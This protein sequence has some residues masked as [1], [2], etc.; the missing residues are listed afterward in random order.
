MA[1]KNGAHV[2]GHGW[3]A[4][5][6]DLKGDALLITK[7]VLTVERRH[8]PTYKHAERVRK[9][10]AHRC[11]DLA[12]GA[13]RQRANG[14][15]LDRKRERPFLPEHRK[16]ASVHYWDT[17]RRCGRC[18]RGC[19]RREWSLR[20]TRVQDLPGSLYRSSPS[21]EPRAAVWPQPSQNACR[22]IASTLD[23]APQTKLSNHS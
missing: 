11:G 3:F 15:V 19:R 21:P 18:D 13:D 8:F 6:A 10:P 14:A 12:G 16:L 7:H 23:S 9:R 5:F 22:A 17:D 4:T 2:G 20:A 1:R